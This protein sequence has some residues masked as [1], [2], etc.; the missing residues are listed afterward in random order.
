MNSTSKYPLN[1]ETSICK[2]DQ[3]C[4]CQHPKGNKVLFESSY[5]NF[6]PLDI[7]FTEGVLIQTFNQP[8]SSVTIDTTC[9][10]VTN[11][12][13]DF[14]GILNV[15]TANVAATSALTF[16]LFKTCT[17]RR[18][19]QTV[20]TANFFAADPVAGATASFTLAFKFPFKNNDCKDCCT[21]IL[22]LTNISNQVAG[23]ITYSVNGTFSALAIVSAC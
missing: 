5:G 9:L 11:T 13:I 19:R 15:T 12:L 16:T 10:N 20:S 14:T 22:E 17:D 6:G 21:Y 8:I 3:D 23:T 4:D 2:K 1:E 18:M 7:T